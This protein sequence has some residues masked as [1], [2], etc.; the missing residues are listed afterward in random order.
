M[1]KGGAG[2]IRFRIP[3]VL[4]VVVHETAPE[5]FAAIRLERLCQHVGTFRVGAPVAERACPV[6]RV[7]FDQKTDE[8]RDMAVSLFRSL[9]P[10]PHDIFVQ[11]VRCCKARGQGQIEF[12]RQQQPYSVQS[13]DIRQFRDLRQIFA[14]YQEIHGGL[15]VDI[16]GRDSVDAHGRQHARVAV[17]PFPVKTDFVPAKKEGTPRVAALYFAVHIVPVVEHAQRVKRP[18]DPFGQFGAAF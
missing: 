9:P 4:I 10:E 12:D 7:C 17:D 15:Y 5:K 1:H 13:K 16:A 14:G 2:A 6:L 18:H 8:V 11:R 3:P